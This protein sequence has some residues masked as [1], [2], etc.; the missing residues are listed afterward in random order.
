MSFYFGNYQIFHY[1]PYMY[2]HCINHWLGLYF[3]VSMRFHILNENKVLA[4]EKY[5]TVLDPSTVN[6]WVWYMEDERG[7][8]KETWLLS[9]QLPEKD[10]EDTLAPQ[11]IECRSP[12]KNGCRQDEW[13]Y[14]E[15]E[16][17]MDWT[18]IKNGNQQDMCDSLDMG[19]QRGKDG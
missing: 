13:S 4:N 10:H 8:Q 7:W 11:N 16:M 19:H 2:I 6:L 18:S 9:K 15:K 12:S 1:N 14:H 3:R 5:F 17:G